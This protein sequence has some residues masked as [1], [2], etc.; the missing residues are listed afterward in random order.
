MAMLLCDLLAALLINGDINDHLFVMMLLHAEC[1][2]QDALYDSEEL[3]EARRV[4]G[5]HSESACKLNSDVL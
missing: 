1:L 4:L 5:E 2:L 3:A